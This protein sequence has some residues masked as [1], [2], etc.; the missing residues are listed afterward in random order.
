MLSNGFKNP[1]QWVQ[2]WV[3]LGTNRFKQMGSNGIKNGFNWI[4]AGLI[5]VQKSSQW[6]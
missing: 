6:V 3:Q 4:N 1:F 5:W 2:K